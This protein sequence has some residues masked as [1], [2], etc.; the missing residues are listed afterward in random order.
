VLSN[1]RISIVDNFDIPINK[2]NEVMTLRKIYDLI[3][4]T[5]RILLRQNY[6][7]VCTYMYIIYKDFDSLWYI[8]SVEINANHH[9]AVL[10]IP[11]LSV[12]ANTWN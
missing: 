2:S 12:C 3:K 1:I 11:G 10:F 5:F 9:F 6:S 4:L 7:M 8:N